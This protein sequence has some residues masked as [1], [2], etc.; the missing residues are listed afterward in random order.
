M[1]FRMGEAAYQRLVRVAR[2]NRLTTSEAIR[3]AIGVY[4]DREEA[5]LTAYDLMADFIGVVDGGN[6]NRSTRTGRQILALLKEQR[7]RQG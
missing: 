1:S 5:G 3:E 7:E 2:R 4:A 6:P